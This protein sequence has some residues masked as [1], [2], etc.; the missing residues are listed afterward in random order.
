[1][2][3]SKSAGLA[4]F[5]FLLVLFQNAKRIPAQNT[6]PSGN[7]LAALATSMKPGTFA[8]LNVEG[9]DSGYGKSV[10]SNG[11]SNGIT[12]FADKMVY[13]A[14]TDRVYF[15]GGEHGGITKTIYY[16]IATN[17]WIDLGR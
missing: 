1:M 16:D 8:L 10:L 15:S 14:A 3:R 5:V 2:T 11:G 6:P 4:L 9:D 7:K 12:G 13:D 17:K